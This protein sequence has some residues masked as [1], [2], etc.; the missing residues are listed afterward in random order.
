MQGMLNNKAYLL[1]C[2]IKEVDVFFSLSILSCMFIEWN[3]PLAHAL[4][5]II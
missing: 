1:H 2:E 5:H 4:M 3:Q